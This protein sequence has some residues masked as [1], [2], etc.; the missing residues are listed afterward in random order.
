MDEFRPVRL[1]PPHDPGIQVRKDASADPARGPPA[2]GRF[3]QKAGAG[4]EASVAAAD[5]VAADVPVQSAALFSALHAEAR[6]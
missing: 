5:V 6:S 2:A 3:C 4:L 1:V